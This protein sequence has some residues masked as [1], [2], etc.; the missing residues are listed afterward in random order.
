M[1]RFD[2]LK[3]ISLAGLSPALI[4]KGTGEA[5]TGG[6]LLLVDPYS[7]FRDCEERGAGLIQCIYR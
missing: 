2:A 3:L 6:G 1:K 7:F 5:H 4:G